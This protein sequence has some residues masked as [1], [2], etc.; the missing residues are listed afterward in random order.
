MT[1]RATPFDYD[2]NLGG[3]GAVEAPNVFQTILGRTYDTLVIKTQASPEISIPLIPQGPSTP[4]GQ[5]VDYAGQLL[6]PKI[7]LRGPSGQVSFAPF[8]EP[9]PAMTAGFGVLAIG[10]LIGVGYALGKFS[11]RRRRRA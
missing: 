8:G 1:K 6:K 3:L 10:G 4:V 7:T 11:E 2:T 5:H 9:S